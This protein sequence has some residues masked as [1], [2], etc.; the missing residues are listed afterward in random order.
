MKIGQKLQEAG[1]RDNTFSFEFFVPKTE[2]GIQNLYDRMDRMYQAK[3]EFI[4]I[5]WNAGGRLSK[6]TTELVS[7]SQSALGLETC[8]HLT[9]TNMPCALIDEALDKAFECGCEN[10]LALRGDPPFQG[11]KWQACEGGF[12]YAKD[13]VQHIRKRYGNHFC[14]G[15]A[16]YPEGDDET[17]DARALI[18]YLKEKVDAGADFI[19]TQMFYDADNFL[20]WCR[21]VRGAG[22]NIPIIPGIMPITSYTAFM[23]RANWCRVNIPREFLERLEPVKEN[24]Q[25]VREIGTEL[26]VN[27]CRKLLD[28]KYVTHLHIYTM[29]LEEAPLKILERLGLLQVD[30][31]PGSTSRQRSLSVESMPWRRSLN[32]QRR[33]ES[34]R[35]IFWQRRPYTYVARTS[36]WSVDEFPNGRFGDSSSPAYGALDLCDRPVLRHSYEKSLKLWSRPETIYDI[37]NL[38]I[39]YL[40]GNIDCLPWSDVPLNH[41]V[42]S[43]LDSLIRHNENLIFTINSQPKA[44]GVP[45][46]DPVFGWGPPDGYVFQKQYLEFLLPRHKLDTLINLIN[47]NY[48]ILTFFSIDN[49]D[50][51]NTNH[52]DDTKAIAVTWGVFPGREVLQPTI[53]EKVSFIA[54]K[55]EFYRILDDWR[56]RFSANGDSKSA[57][58]LQTIIN[59]YALVTIVDNNFISNDDMIGKLLSCLY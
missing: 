36:Q 5:T 25:A 53:V 16:A 18:P 29:N 19:I 9:C 40:K 56:L 42:D 23:R 51:L 3:P 4:D 58:L 1:S 35:P 57:E 13:L 39:N 26:V 38:I 52:P 34:I 14:I 22:I 46:N 45:S 15:V 20:E 8:M 47:T 41:E 59:D 17:P 50:N 12:R 32:P 54:W 10:I 49:E 2:Q 30:D 24:D 28:S 43:I 27:M 44:N 7:T 33:K 37:A 21:L 31:S 48:S 55:E 11:G 6:Q